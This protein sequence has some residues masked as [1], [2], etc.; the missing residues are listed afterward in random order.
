M[1]E[2]VSHYVFPVK[3]LRAKAF[4]RELSDLLNRYGIDI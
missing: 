1:S 3:F 2:I 4:K